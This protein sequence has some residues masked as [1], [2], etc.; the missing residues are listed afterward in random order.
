LGDVTRVKLFEQWSSNSKRDLLLL[1]Q[2]AK[3]G[4][5]VPKFAQ[6]SSSV[7]YSLPEL[8]KKTQKSSSE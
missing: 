8:I 3:N 4:S 5:S 1:R 6:I 2:I 7:L